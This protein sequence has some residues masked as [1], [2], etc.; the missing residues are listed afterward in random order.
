MIDRVALTTKPAPVDMGDNKTSTVTLSR[1][2]MREP[3]NPDWQG[4]PEVFKPLQ[5][6]PQLGMKWCC[7]CGD[8]VSKKGFS[9]NKGNRDGLQ[10]WCKECRNEY[11]RKVYAG[12]KQSAFVI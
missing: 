2:P 7:H 5:F 11:R 9:P 6:M 3:K 12:G 1:V 10:S 4:A 8:W